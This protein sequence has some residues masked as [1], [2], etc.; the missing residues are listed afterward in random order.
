MPFA[1][2]KMPVEIY[3]KYPP[4]EKEEEKPQEETQPENK[5]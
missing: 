3:D 5:E 1:K 4:R 2:R